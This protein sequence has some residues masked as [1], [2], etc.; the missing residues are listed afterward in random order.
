MNKVK[1]GEFLRKLREEKKLSQA[2]LAEEFSKAYMEVSTNAISSWEKGKSI[3]DI[4]KLNFLADYFK[5]S[6]DDIL[7]GEKYEEIDFDNVY[8]IH[9]PEY[10][11]HKDF[12]LKVSKED[13]TTNPIYYSITGEGEKIR[14]RLKK[15][16]FSLIDDKI[17]R[18]DTKEL[19]YLLKNYFILCDDLSITTYFGFLRQLKNKDMSNEEKWW[20]AQRYF[21]PIDLLTLTF[22]NLSDEGYLLPT[23]Q[24]RMNYSEPWEKDAL[25]AMIQIADPIYCNP[26]EGTSKYIEKYEIEHGKQFDKERI[27][28]DTIKY[29]IK[30]GAMINRNF[31]SFQQGEVQETRVIDT[32]ET[33]HNILVKPISFCVRDNDNLKFYYA[34]NNR[35]NRFYSKYDYHLV[36]PLQKLGYSVDEIFTFVDKNKTIP[37]EVYLKMAKISGVDTNREFR[38]IKADTHFNTDMLVLERYWEQY[39]NEEYKEYLEQRDNLDIFETELSNGNF[40]NSTIN[41]RTIGGLNIN[42]K[43]NYIVNKKFDLTYQEFKKGRQKARTKELIEALDSLTIEE[44]RNQFFKLGG[45]EN[46]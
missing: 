46:D 28:K 37:D 40:V 19:S 16:I 45:Q 25:L 17:S 9:Q 6:I 44:I 4:D 38:F 2:K 8:H 20:E 18:S 35:R 7:D 12:A 26:N 43:Y 30:N 21:Y 23:I 33:A 1:M 39:H 22:G 42:E 3:P 11:N 15:H 29:L 10:F 41:L 36:K 27:I 31:L 13:P 5:T 14:E 34:K 24:R 32:L